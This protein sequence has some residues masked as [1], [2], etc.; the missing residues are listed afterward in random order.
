MDFEIEQYSYSSN[1][2]SNYLIVSI[3]IY[4]YCLKQG[5]VYWVSDKEI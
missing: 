5:G 3:V 2:N 1:N 4:L